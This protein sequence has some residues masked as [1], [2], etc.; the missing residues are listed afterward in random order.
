M[1]KKA[2]IKKVEKELIEEEE[3]EA[4]EASEEEEVVIK[5]IAGAISLKEN[6]K[7]KKKRENTR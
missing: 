7:T 1:V 5:A 2:I 6:L 4:E 3:E